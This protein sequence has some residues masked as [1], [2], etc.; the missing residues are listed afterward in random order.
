M[1]ADETEDLLHGARI[2]GNLEVRD[3]PGGVGLGPEGA[4][5]RH[6]VHD[7]VGIFRLGFEENGHPVLP[8]AVIDLGIALAFLALRQE[9]GNVLIILHPQGGQ[10]AEAQDDSRCS[11]R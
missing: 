3:Q 4:E 9:R 5:S 2:G 7:V 1:G 8:E 11:A 10:G 6:R